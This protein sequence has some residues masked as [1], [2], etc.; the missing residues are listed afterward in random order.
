MSGPGIDGPPGVT[1]RPEGQAGVTGVI[2]VTGPSRTEKDVIHE[3]KPQPADRLLS[4]EQRAIWDIFER[5]KV[6]C[7]KKNFDYGC[8]VFSPPVMAP[9]LPP[10]SAI[11][12]RMSDK[13]KR[14]QSLRLREGGAI[15]ES[16]QDTMMDLG[17]YCFLWLVCEQLNRPAQHSSCTA[18]VD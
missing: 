7:L 5:A 11:E 9:D 1:G 10:E 2:G 18:A 12:V 15:D 4:K 13:I 16:V 17:V 3:M 6:T 14:L 8:S